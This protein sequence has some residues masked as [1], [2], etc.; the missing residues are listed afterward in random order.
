[1]KFQL[2]RIAHMRALIYAAGL[3]FG[4]A[5]S[6][7]AASV[8]EIIHLKGNGGLGSSFGYSSGDLTF[9]VTAYQHSDG[10]LG[11]SISAGQWGYG[12]G[13]QFSGTDPLVNSGEMLVFS[14]NR[15]VTLERVWVNGFDADDDLSLAS[16]GANL[17]LN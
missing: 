10:T 1:M 16:Y 15:V 9:S 7:Q 12:L 13:A 14:F 3:A 17:V 6:A 2:W 5:A 4:L 11:S 8:H